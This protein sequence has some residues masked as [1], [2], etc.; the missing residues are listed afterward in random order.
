MI[1]QLLTSL[2]PTLGFSPAVIVFNTVRITCIICPDSS[3]VSPYR[4][5]SAAFKTQKVRFDCVACGRSEQPTVVAVLRRTDG[6][7]FK[8][9]PSLPPPRPPKG[10]D[11]PT[12]ARECCF[13]DMLPE[14]VPVPHRVFMCLRSASQQRG[15]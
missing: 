9:L 5:R 12:G 11:G 3:V 15:H 6:S 13:C 7:L 1:D 4:A 2:L 14:R 8:G 10:R